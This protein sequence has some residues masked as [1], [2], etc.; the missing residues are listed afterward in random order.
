MWIC[1]IAICR[2]IFLKPLRDNTYLLVQKMKILLNNYCLCT[3]SLIPKNYELSI[4]KTITLKHTLQLMNYNEVYFTK[5][6]IFMVILM[7]FS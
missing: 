6:I 7:T 5:V 3:F 2:S 4:L 1:V